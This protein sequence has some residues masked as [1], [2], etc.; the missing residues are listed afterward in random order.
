RRNLDGIRRMTRLPGVLVIVDVKREYIAIREARKLGIPTI[1]VVDTDS[2]P[3]T[4]DIII[5]GNDD[6]MRAIDIIVAQLAD[7]VEEGKRARAPGREAAR[8]GEDGAGQVAPRRSRRLTT[9][10]TA[11]QGSREESGETATGTMEPPAM[12]SEAALLGQHSGLA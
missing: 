3:E 12:M 5:P 9:T 2:D 7:A 6:A 4:A 10:A 8:G 1:C 11:E